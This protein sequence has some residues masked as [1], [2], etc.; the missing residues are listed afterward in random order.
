MGKIA[1]L[2]ETSSG[3]LC[4]G[5]GISSGTTG[6]ASAARRWWVRLSRSHAV[7]LAILAVGL[8]G[9]TG[10]ARAD[11]FAQP[12][13][14]SGDQSWAGS[15]SSG[16]KSGFDKLGNMA[17]PKPAPEP[18]LSKDDPTSLKSKAKAGP[19]LNV[20]V[21]RTGS[22]PRT[23]RK[24]SSSIGSRYS[25]SPIICRHCWVTPN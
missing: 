19:E 15:I 9:L 4:G 23:T 17:S 11:N 24:Q 20:A 7:S 22:K 5:T 8:L 25:A 3:Q 18:T 2:P 14:A 6:V 16:V 21:A 13:P 10:T 1:I 12:A